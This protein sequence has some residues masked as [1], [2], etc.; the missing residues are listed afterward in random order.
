MRRSSGRVITGWPAVLLAPIVVPIA[1]VAQL[2]S[3][4]KTVDRTPQ[5]V[6]GFID[7][8]LEETGGDWDWD[9]FVSVP[10]TDLELDALRQRAALAAPAN[11][12]LTELRDILAEAQ[13]I[14]GRRAITFR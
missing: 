13:Q 2:L 11:P 3:G 6:I 14:A 1:L 9:E 10:I 4:R 7:D 8:F 12:N 5:D